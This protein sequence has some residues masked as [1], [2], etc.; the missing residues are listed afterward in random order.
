MTYIGGTAGFEFDTI[1]AESS[2]LSS[3]CVIEYDGIFYWVGTDRFL[4]FNGVVREVENGLNSNFFFDNLNYAQRQKVYAFK[5]PRFGEIWWCFPFGDSTEANHAVIYNVRENT[6]Y[7]TAL[8]ESGRGAATIPAIFRNPVATGVDRQNSLLYGATVASRGLGYA[9]GDVV[10]VTGGNAVFPA[11]V[12]VETV[13]GAGQVQTVS[14]SGQGSYS[15]TPTGYNF[16]TNT[17]AGVGVGLRLSLAF[18]RPYK[19]WVHEV[20]VDA[21]SGSDVSPIQSYFETADISLPVSAQTNKA[22]RVA[23]VEPDFVQTGPMTASIHGRANA[24][25]PEVESVP[26]T[27]PETAGT[28]QEQVVFFKEQRRQLRFRFESNCVG[29]DYQMGLILAHIPPSDGTVLG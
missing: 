21:V 28:P 16:P 2:I 9:V 12:T 27:I 17:G 13:G 23:L 22:L 14:V 20:G 24:R 19:L 4:Q 5:V 3:S 8:P 29:G 18:D 11:L 1:S 7:D 10:T 15:A 26:L 25:S 6:W